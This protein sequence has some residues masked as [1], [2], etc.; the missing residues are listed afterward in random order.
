M[1]A[2][3]GLS[4]RAL[5]TVKDILSKYPG[6]QSAVLYGSRAKGNYKNG[7][8]IDITLH[9]DDAFT[10]KDLLDLKGDFDE[11]DLPHMVDVSNYRT[12]ENENLKDHIRR[13]GKVL[14]ERQPGFLSRQK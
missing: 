3:Y 4:N 10:Y 1:A 14:Y 13:V 8:D 12:L 5:K 11:S 2:E 9:T 6:I 7:S